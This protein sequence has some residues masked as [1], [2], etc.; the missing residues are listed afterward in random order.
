MIDQTYIH[1]RYNEDSAS[2]DWYNPLKLVKNII[3]MLN[4]NQSIQYIGFVTSYLQN[5]YI[6][7]LTLM[8]S[9]SS[10]C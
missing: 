1:I 3:S 6:K 4:S 2:E 9:I 7:K 10:D 8:M 5:F